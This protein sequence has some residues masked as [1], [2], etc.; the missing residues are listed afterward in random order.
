MLIIKADLFLLMYDNCLVIQVKQ[1][2]NEKY[3]K[4]IILNI[5]SKITFR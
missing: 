1:R 4:K 2:K 5:L 3:R